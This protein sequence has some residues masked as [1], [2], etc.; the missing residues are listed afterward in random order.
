MANPKPT[1]IGKNGKQGFVWKKNLQSGDPCL[2]SSID[3]V[4]L[5]RAIDAITRRGGAVM[6]GVTSDGGAYS[7]VVLHENDKLKEYP[8]TAEELTDLLGQITEEFTD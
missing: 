6:L 3:A 2:Y 8:H 1:Q 7:I 5:R 4:V